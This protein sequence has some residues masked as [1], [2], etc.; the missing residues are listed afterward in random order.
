MLRHNRNNVAGNEAK[1]PRWRRRSTRRS[2]AFLYAGFYG[3]EEKEKKRIGLPRLFDFRSLWSGGKEE[4]RG[5]S[6]INACFIRAKYFHPVEKKKMPEKQTQA[7]LR[8]GGGTTVGA[9]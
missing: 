5:H 4:V 3:S 8:T 2:A 9:C 7:R 1:G 6:E